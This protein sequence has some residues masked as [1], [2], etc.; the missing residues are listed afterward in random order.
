MQKSNSLVSQYPMSRAWIRATLAAAFFVV[1]M[2][3]AG[4]ADAQDLSTMTPEQLQQLQQ[5]QQAQQKLGDRGPTTPLGTTPQETILQPT[6]PANPALPTSRLEVILSARAGAKLTQFGYSQLG[7]GR[8]VTISQMGAVQDDY[9]LGPGD[10]I[11]V[12]L[13]GQ[14]KAEY[15]TTVD[16]DGRVVLP[17]LDPVSASGRTFGDFRRD[18]I[19]AIHSSYVATEGFVSIGHVRQ[20]SVLVSGEVGNPGIRI[21]NGLTTPV[22]AILVSGGVKKSGS[23]RNIYILRGNR[24]IP[25]DLYSVLTGHASSARVALADGDRILVPP[26]GAAVAVAGS[27]RRPAIYEL[28]AG[29]K[30]ISVRELLALASGPTLPGIYTASILRLMSDGKLQFVD[31]SNA[32]GTQVHDGE[33]F[34]LK[35]AVNISLG[36]V[37]LGGAVRTPGAFALGKY[38]TLRDLLPS[39]E[40]FRPGAYVLFGIIDRTDPKTMQR[41]ALPFSPLHVIQGRENLNLISDDSVHI[42]TKRGMRALLRTMLSPEPPESSEHPPG[43]GTETTPGDTE[44]A[45]ANAGT[46]TPAGSESVTPGGVNSEQASSRGAKTGIGTAQ[47]GASETAVGTA[48]AGAGE[49]PVGTAQAGV[50]ETPVAEG[51]AEAGEADLGGYTSSEGAFFG[52]T[53][54]DYR[55]NISGAVHD[56]GLYLVAPDTTLAEALV[57]AGGLTNDVDLS[58][59]ELTS[60]VIDNNSGAST[61]NRNRYPATAEEFSR[62]ILKPF[63]KINFRHA[64]SDKDGGTVRI[65]GEVRYPGTYDILRGETLLSVLVR[66]GGVTKVSYP[67]GT[68]FLRKS[69]AKQQAAEFRRIATD[70]RSQMLTVT[71]RPAGMNTTPISP[72]SVVA[73][74]SLVNQIERQPALGRVSIIADPTVLSAHPNRDLLLEPG[75]SIVIPQRPNTVSVLGEVLRPGAFPFDG[76]LSVDDYIA[77]AGGL[78]EFADSSRVIVVLPDGEARIKE[79]SWLSFGRGNNIPPGSMIV[80]TRELAGLSIHQLIVDTTQIFSQLATTTAALA[81]LSKY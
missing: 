48:Q 77:S 44:A 10:E 78:T 5:F 13:R 33:A 20:V 72:E 53:L 29:Q 9:V 16:R 4:V 63:D 11:V 69:V 8:Q 54:G 7:V 61:T 17:R 30:V 79:G 81:V 15:R 43:T 47:A 60:T 73:L 70:I 6:A 12:S 57:A 39:A 66:A 25:I 52:R 68:V 71:M 21:L 38:P 75:D 22:D 14:E 3:A 34:I 36:R 55:V 56:P 1:G 42:L 41:V 59:F 2:F 58:N 50:G 46:A 32:P 45:A 31:V 67:Y 23:L 65:A 40:A 51:E 35:S 64:Y 80:A 76:S 24:R 62:T 19:N 18:M 49:T 37:T 28:P 27:V 74:Q 26:I